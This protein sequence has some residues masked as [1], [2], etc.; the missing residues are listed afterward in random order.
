VNGREVEFLAADPVHLLADDLPDAQQGAL[1]QR[2]VGVDAGR[3]LADEAAAQQQHMADHV[4]LGGH[5]AQGGHEKMAESHAELL[6]GC[7]GRTC[8]I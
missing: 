7:P 5:L 3:Q 6:R 8:K 2:Q 4:G 1:G